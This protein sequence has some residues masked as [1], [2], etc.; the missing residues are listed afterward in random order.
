MGVKWC[1]LFDSKFCVVSD[2]ALE[3]QWGGEKTEHT[4]TYMHNTLNK[5]VCSSTHDSPLVPCAA[6]FWSV[7]ISR[8]DAETQRILG[9]ELQVGKAEK[10]CFANAYKSWRSITR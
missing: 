8:S 6:D 3:V 10:N 5:Q 9:F 2:A 1:R 7:T 4:H